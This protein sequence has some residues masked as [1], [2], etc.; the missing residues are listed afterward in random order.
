MCLEKTLT[1]T[2]F[3]FDKQVDVYVCECGQVIKEI[4]DIQLKKCKHN[5][6]CLRDRVHNRGKGK[7]M[8]YKCFLC[9]KFQRRLL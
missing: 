9:G 5:W 1:E 8:A 4:T 3:V 6:E 2:K 7:Y